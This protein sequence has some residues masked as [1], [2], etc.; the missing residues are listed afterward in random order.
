MRC[1]SLAALLRYTWSLLTCRLT[2]LPPPQFSGQDRSVRLIVRDTGDGMAPE[3]RERI[4]EPFFTTKNIGEGTGMG[5]VVV[6]GIVTSYG[7]HHCGECS[8]QGTTFAVYLPRLVA[9]TTPTVDTE[10][11]LPGCVSAW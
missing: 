11:P 5:L 7:G 6:H 8:R 4:F 3:I 10:E 9:P 2:V 1:A